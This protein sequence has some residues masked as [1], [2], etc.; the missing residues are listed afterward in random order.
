MDYVNG[1]TR[2][3]LFAKHLSFDTGLLYINKDLSSDLDAQEK[4][5]EAAKKKAQED[6]L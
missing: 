2:I 6:K 4:A 1:S 5:E 3:F